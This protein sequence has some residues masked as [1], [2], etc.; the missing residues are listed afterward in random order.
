MILLLVQFVTVVCL[1]FL[2]TLKVLPSRSVY[3]MT[4]LMPFSSRGVSK[5]APLDLGDSMPMPS[6]SSSSTSAHLRPN[7]AVDMALDEWCR[8]AARTYKHPTS[9]MLLSPGLGRLHAH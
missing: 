3:S 7:L 2:V 4:V 6:S 9:A 5:R 8:A 1:I